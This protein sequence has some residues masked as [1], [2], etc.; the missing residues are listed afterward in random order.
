MKKEFLFMFIGILLISGVLA[1][2]N[3]AYQNVVVNVL[4]TEMNV[5]SPV[6]GEIYNFNK[7]PMNITVYQKV[8]KIEYINFYDKLSRWRTLCRDCD[9]YGDKKKKTKT[10]DEGENN[11]SIRA[12]DGEVEFGAKNIT[13]FI[14]SIDPKIYKI[15]PKRRGFT[16][17]TFY[18]RYREENVDKVTLSYNPKLGLELNNCEESRSYTECYFDVDLSAYDGREIEYNLTIEDIA[19]NTDSKAI[20]KV[21]VDT[22][23]PV[24][25]NPDSFWNKDGRKV[26]FSLNVTEPNFDE[27]NYIDYTDKNPKEKVLCSSLKNGICKKSRT[28]SRG[29]HN[30]TINILDKVGNS[31]TIKEVIFQV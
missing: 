9:E 26:T 30:I 14:D 12:V 18:M 3:V 21:K 5:Y 15:E 8:D 20:E 23:A 16:N 19:G 25:N 6:Q 17:G 2:A 1:V 10:F 27:I 24:L 13:F 11:I 31:E 28:F 29:D 4:P 22:S 7:I